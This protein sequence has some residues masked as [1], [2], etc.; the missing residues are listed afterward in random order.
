M[1]STIDYFSLFGMPVSF[2]L[3]LTLLGAQYR[4]IQAEVHPDRFVNATPAERLQSMQFATIANE[5]YQTLKNPTSRARYLL[6]QQGVATLDD[7]NTAMPSDFLMLQMEWREALEEA[8]SNRN[9]AAI[10]SLL[11]TIRKTK[12]ELQSGLGKQIETAP[13]QAALSVRKL[14]FIDKI[15]T[16]IE[17]QLDTL[18]Q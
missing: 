11:V 6:K 18:L 17:Q 3:D 16:D 2:D 10:E 7:S 8:V 4:K 5:A 1:N 9:V 14:S 13:A 15:S 12:I